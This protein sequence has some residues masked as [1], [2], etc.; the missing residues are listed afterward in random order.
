MGKEKFSIDIALKNNGVCKKQ[1][2]SCS[3][4]QLGK[5]IYKN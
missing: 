3:N 1:K 4:C 2:V 5:F